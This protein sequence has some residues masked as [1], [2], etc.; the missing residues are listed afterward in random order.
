MTRDCHRLTAIIASHQSAETLGT[1]ELLRLT[2]WMTPPVHTE[3]RYDWAD[4]VAMPVIVELAK[5]LVR[6]QSQQTVDTP[7][8]LAKLRQ[9]RT[10]QKRAALSSIKERLELRHVAAMLEAE[11]DQIIADELQPG[12][13]DATDAANS[14]ETST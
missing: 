2:Q 14:T 1:H 12:L 11:V 3:R 7:A 9:M 8:L 5:R 6:I 13:F 10:A 4:S